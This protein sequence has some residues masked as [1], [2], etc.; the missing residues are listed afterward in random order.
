MFVVEADK[1][2]RREIRTGIRGTNGIEVL[3]GLD[4]KARVVSPYPADLTD[5]ARVNITGAQER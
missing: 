1:A 3:S 4:E 2:W 5:G